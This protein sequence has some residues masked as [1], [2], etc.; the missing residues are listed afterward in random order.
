[1]KDWFNCKIE[2]FTE[3]PIYNKNHLNHKINSKNYFWFSMSTLLIYPL[4]LAGLLWEIAEQKSIFQILKNQLG[5][6]I[7]NS[8]MGMVHYL[9][10]FKIIYGSCILI[11]LIVTILWIEVI[12]ASGTDVSKVIKIICIIILFASLMITWGQLNFVKRVIDFVS[13]NNNLYGLNISDKDI[14][15]IAYLF[16][17][18]NLIEIPLLFC[19]KLIYNFI[20]IVTYWFV[21]YRFKVT[22]LFSILV[23]IFEL[24]SY[25]I[26]WMISDGSLQNIR[27]L[28]PFMGLSFISILIANEEKILWISF[29]ITIYCFYN[30]IKNNFDRLLL[31]NS[32][33]LFIGNLISN[34]FKD[35]VSNQTVC[36]LFYLFMSMSIAM[37]ICEWFVLTVRKIKYLGEKEKKTIENVIK[38]LFGGLAGS[39]IMLIIIILEH[40]L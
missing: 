27:S 19:I 4:V 40:F 12:I 36:Y 3:L 14:W 28:L 23:I 21:C 1:M 30:A 17:L 29:I 22:L 10:L 24:I 39:S 25:G 20:F 32:F 18:G 7:K 26:I 5:L 9:Q 11:Y 35:N 38:N 34:L 37:Y 6:W 31:T 15:C 16:K 2:P 33:I 13:R 8:N